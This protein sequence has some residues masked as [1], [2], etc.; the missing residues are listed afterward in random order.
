MAKITGIKHK[1]KGKLYLFEDIAI[2]EGK[3]SA[4]GKFMGNYS[5]IPAT[6]LGVSVVKNILES[7]QISAEAID[8]VIFANTIPSSPDAIFLPRHIALQ[9]GCDIRT[10]ASMVQ[11]ICASGM[12][13]IITAASEVAL[14]C[15]DLVIA[16]GAENM[17]R[18]PLASFDIRN[19]FHLGQKPFVDL[20]WEG[21]N[22]SYCS[23]SMG[24]TA[25]NLAKKYVI[26]REEV[27]DFAFLSHTRAIEAKKNGLFDAES[28]YCTKLRE[29]ET[30]RR[31]IDRKKL[32]YLKSVFGAEGVQTAG[33]SSQ[34]AD[35]A[36]AVL[37]G[38]YSAETKPIGKI[39]AA[40]IIGEIPEIMGIAPVMAIENLL[41]T[42]EITIADID[43]WEIN[44][45]FGAQY[46]A[47]E[48]EL[49]LDRSCVNVNGGSIAIGH[50]L[51]ATG[52][53]LVTTLLYE[54]RRRNLKYGIASAC[55]GGGQGTAIMVEA[56]Y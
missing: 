25:E 14:G 50:P 45:A 4:F 15:S 48:K 20:L 44:E 23:C 29:D 40:S 47:V 2:I 43:L 53:R 1:N 21:L 55:V 38:N 26:T 49:K 28:C 22:D 3:R 30:I 12:E 18:A 5:A 10:P 11:R 9:V 31:E 8:Q 37:V 39:H 19:G 54:L 27:D 46:L 32:G 52:I 34:I 41:N 51:G 42:L 24:Q 56:C 33:N 16:G 7:R 6:E 35:G 13:A 36:A 17:T